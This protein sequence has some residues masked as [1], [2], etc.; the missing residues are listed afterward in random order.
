MLKQFLPAAIESNEAAIGS[1]LL[2]QASLSAWQLGCAF[3]SRLQ[4]HQ[5]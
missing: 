4:M 1:Q 3:H 2:V 5:R